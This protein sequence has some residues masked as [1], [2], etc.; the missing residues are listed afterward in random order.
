M[1]S[2]VT[3]GKKMFSDVLVAKDFYL[4]HGKNS[5]KS[6]KRKKTIGKWGKDLNRHFTKGTIWSINT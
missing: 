6:L 4:V 5:N 2:Q 3:E 1:E